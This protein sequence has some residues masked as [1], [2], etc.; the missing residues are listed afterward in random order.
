MEK[1]ELFF[2]TVFCCMSC[3][4][5]I[6]HEEVELVKDVSKTDDAFK[7]LDVQTLLDKWVK[8]INDKGMLFLKTYLNEL[9]ATELSEDEQLKIVDLAIKMIEADNIIKYSEV[10]FFKKIRFRLSISDEA[11][12]KIHPDKEDF[13]LPDIMVKEDPIWEGVHFDNIIL[14]NLKLQDTP[15]A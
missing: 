7:G 10:S 13:L 1:N 6:A 9:S 14:N 4:G 11:I 5:D 3:D 2:K 15:E 8:E 12:L